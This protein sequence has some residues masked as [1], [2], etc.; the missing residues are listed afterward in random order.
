[1]QKCVSSG[2]MAV[3]AKEWSS[4]PGQG[5]REIILSSYYKLEGKILYLI[6]PNILLNLVIWNNG[7]MVIVL[8]TT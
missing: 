2:V 7:I 6:L 1:M 3:V 8:S 5:F 4:T